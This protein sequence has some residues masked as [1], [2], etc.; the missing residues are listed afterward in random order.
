MSVL[1]EPQKT[2]KKCSV[3]QVRGM[4]DVKNCL[5][6]DFG[7]VLG[8][9]VHKDKQGPSYLSGNYNV[10]ALF[11]PLAEFEIMVYCCD[12][13]YMKFENK[14]LTNDQAAIKSKKSERK[15]F[16]IALIISL[17]WISISILYVNI[18]NPPPAFLMAFFGFILPALSIGITSIGFFSAIGELK[19]LKKR[20]TLIVQHSLLK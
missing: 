9:N 7:I 5:T 19:K 11:T 10:G 20:I 18:F 6:L 13:C 3:C 8:C 15:S 1:N 16:L 14:N 2:T 4:V 12:N 17:I